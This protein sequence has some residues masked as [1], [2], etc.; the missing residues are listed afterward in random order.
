MSLFTC[1]Q[2]N[3]ADLRHLPAMIA[4]ADLSAH[5]R[6][7][8]RAQHDPPV[9]LRNFFKQEYFELSTRMRVQSPEPRRN[10]TG[11][12]QDEDVSGTQ[13]V[14]QVAKFAMCDMARI[15]VENEKSGLVAVLS[16][17]L[18]DKFVG[19]LEVELGCEHVVN[20]FE[21]AQRL[22]PKYTGL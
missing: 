8:A 15:T 1:F 5:S 19:E 6:A 4:N 20:I 3:G 9:I 16:R 17:G 10:H 2:D 14:E 12:V 18:G 22:N 7:F 21:T 11:I 13:V